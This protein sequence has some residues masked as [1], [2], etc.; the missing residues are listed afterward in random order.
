[1]HKLVRV[2]ITGMF[3]SF[4]GSLPLGTLNVALMQISISDG[5][6]P[7]LLFGFGSLTAEVVYVRLSLIAMDWIRTHVPAE[8]RI[9]LGV[10]A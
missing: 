1:M 4:L 6:T 10:S 3:I 9:L 2:F 7:A 8:A 5:I